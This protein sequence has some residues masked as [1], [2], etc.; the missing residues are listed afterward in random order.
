MENPRYT[1]NAN[2]PKISVA[3][4]KPSSSHTTEKIKSLN[5]SGKYKNFCRLCP[6]PVSYTHLDVYKR[7][8]FAPTIFF[9]V[10]KINVTG[11]TRYTSEQLI[12]STGVK[13][14]DNMF[15]LDTEQIAADLKD[16]YP[17][18][19]TVKRCV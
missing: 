19:D 1:K 15:F 2:N 5:G 12:K 10:S 14:G 9:Q 4:I 16:E 7:Q 3:P 8:V 13:Q 6:S 17:Y 18:L 11:D